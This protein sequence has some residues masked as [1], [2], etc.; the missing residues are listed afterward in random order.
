MAFRHH[1]VILVDEY[2][3]IRAMMASQAVGEAG[4]RGKQLCLA[5]PLPHDPL[6]GFA[7]NLSQRRTFEYVAMTHVLG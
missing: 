7:F 4:Q 2:D 1:V 3:H 5:G 6:E